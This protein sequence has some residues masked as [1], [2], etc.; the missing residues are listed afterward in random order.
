MKTMIR[1]VLLLAVAAATVALFSCS[2]LGTSISQRVGDFVSDLNSNRANAY[3]NLDPNIST[4]STTR[5]TTTYWD[6]TFGTNTP[7]TFSPDP[8]TPSGS[9]ATI[10]LYDKS[11][12]SLGAY[13]FT[14]VN[15]GGTGAEHWVIETMSGPGGSF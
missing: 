10:T 11:A 7:F 3:L 15:I 8:A 2:L 1:I 14:F 9:S 4:Y 6:N 13:T 12:V 5:G